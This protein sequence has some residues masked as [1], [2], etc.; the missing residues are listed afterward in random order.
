MSAQGWI[1]SSLL[2]TAVLAS[3]AWADSSDERLRQFLARIRPEPSGAQ[4]SGAV[5]SA[6][7]TVPPERL[8]ERFELL[9]QG[10]LDL[11]RL[12]VDAAQAAFE[13]AALILH[14]ADSEIALV[15]SYMQAGEYR[16]ALAFGAH[17]AGA[18]LDVVGGTA[19]YAWLLHG[20]GQHAAAARLLDDAAARLPDNA[21]IKSVQQQLASGSLVPG[22]DMLALPT[23]LAPYASI[24]GLP[25]GARVVSSAVLLPTTAQGVGAFALMPL[26]VLTLQRVGSNG[27]VDQALWL[28]N[29]L[30]QLSHAS[31]EKLLPGVGVAVLRLMTPLPLPDGLPVA[32]ANPFPG[33]VGYI[34]EYPPAAAMQ[35]LAAAWPQLHMGFVGGMATPNDPSS[36][37]RLLGISL[38]AGPRGGGLFNA[39]GQFSGLTVP[40]KNGGPDL[41]VTIGQLRLALGSDAATFGLEK[42]IRPADGV[43]TATA[44][45]TPTSVPAPI[46]AD[47]IYEASLKNTLQVISN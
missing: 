45:A 20:G 5:P 46:S 16:R 17:T 36:D 25:A 27:Q 44:T 14:A 19:M 11:S 47:K 41:L 32:T 34:V 23:R 13:K 1:R 39:A 30:G 37:A 35:P 2:S 26:K 3:N 43:S 10:E 21:F 28:R 8:K 29:G 33:S 9:A 18:H 12:Q 15:R 22:N 31:I 7:A 24:D 42:P 40:A 38:R 6:A 4:A